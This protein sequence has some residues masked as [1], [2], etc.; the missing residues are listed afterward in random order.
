MSRSTGPWDGQSVQ[1]IKSYR[2]L[3]Q[4]LVGPFLK[5]FI[6][7]SFQKAH[8][9]IRWAG[10][11]ANA[12]DTKSLQLANFRQT[13]SHHDVDRKVYG[14]DEGRDRSR[15]QETHRVDAISS[16]V[17]VCSGPSNRFLES[18]IFVP[19]SKSQRVSASI[20]HY[21]NPLGLAQLSYRFDI[22]YL[23]FNRVEFLRGVCEIFDVYSIAP[24]FR[25][26]LTV[27][28]TSLVV[29][30]KPATMS[31]ERGTDTTLAI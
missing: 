7:R 21:R 22:L 15:V 27:T 24:V 30:P 25:I 20:Y 5:H 26:A 17:P 19:L 29:F 31:A 11:E 12:C 6:G 4:A 16:R 1:L 2:T 28:S 8:R 13:L 3:S 14:Q 9:C 23:S 18:C 10:T